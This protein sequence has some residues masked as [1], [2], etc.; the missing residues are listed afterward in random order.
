MIH[1]EQDHT[2]PLIGGFREQ[3]FTKWQHNINRISKL[4]ASD[5]HTHRC[6]GKNIKD[7]QI[8]C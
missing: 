6:M 4:D 7:S 5:S 3:H 1:S 8:D 2:P